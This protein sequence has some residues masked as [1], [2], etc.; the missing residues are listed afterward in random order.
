VTRIEQRGAVVIFIALVI[1]VWG[2]F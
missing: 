1:A 2:L